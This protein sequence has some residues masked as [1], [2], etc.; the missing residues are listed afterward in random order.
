VKKKRLR[1]KEAG[2]RGPLPKGEDKDDSEEK[3]GEG[4]QVISQ[5]LRDQAIPWD[6]LELL[7]PLGEGNFGIIY[8]ARYEDKNV[9]VKLPKPDSRLARG[10]LLDFY[11]EAEIQMYVLRMVF[12]IFGALTLTPYLTSGCSLPTL[13]FLMYWVC[14]LIKTIR[15]SFLT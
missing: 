3:M 14:V 4:R 1:K 6:E 5:A 9:A 12:L 10:A 7:E 15:L 8:K 13:I 2:K 11:F